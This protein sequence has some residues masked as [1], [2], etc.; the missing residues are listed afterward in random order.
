M[1]NTSKI[2]KNKNQQ[3]KEKVTWLVDKIPHFFG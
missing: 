2:L 3:Q 1:K